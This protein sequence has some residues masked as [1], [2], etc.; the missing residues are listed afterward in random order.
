MRGLAQTGPLQIRA[1]IKTNKDTI[2]MIQ[3]FMIGTWKESIMGWSMVLTPAPLC[4]R[5]KGI[6]LA[7]R[8]VFHISIITHE[9][10]IIDCFS[11]SV[12]C[13]LTALQCLDNPGPDYSQ[14]FFTFG[15]AR[16]ARAA[17]VVAGESPDLLVPSERRRRRDSM[18]WPGSSPTTLETNT[19]PVNSSLGESTPQLELSLTDWV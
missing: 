8:C 16:P 5:Q 17:G 6:F 3:W 4:H 1:E 9:G 10:T 15:R 11:F 7:W 12:L 18:D 13:W 19:E 14:H 2:I